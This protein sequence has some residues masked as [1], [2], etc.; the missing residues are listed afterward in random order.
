MK[1]F[2][3]NITP[4]SPT[5]PG[6]LIKEE[7]EFRKL[8]QRRLASQMGVSYTVLNEILNSKRSVNVEFALLIEAA[9]GLEADMLINMQSRYNLQTA[10]KDKS[11]MKKLKEVRENCLCKTGFR[12]TNIH[13]THIGNKDDVFFNDRI[14]QTSLEI[15]LCK[16]EYK[17]HIPAKSYIVFPSPK[18]RK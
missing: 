7:I 18:A 13:N 10:C 15:D 16:E 17:H 9:L 6:E 1:T 2:A 3:N 12:E 14:S 11:F 5:H 4:F 8:S